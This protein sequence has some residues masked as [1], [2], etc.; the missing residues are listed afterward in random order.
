MC[1]IDIMLQVSRFAV[2]KIVYKYTILI[3]EKKTVYEVIGTVFV[4][5]V[6]Q[7]SVEIN[8]EEKVIHTF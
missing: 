6:F 5:K 7:R 8:N 3:F 1:K 2:A 4:S